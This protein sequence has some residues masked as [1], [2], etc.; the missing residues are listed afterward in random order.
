M[1]KLSKETNYDWYIKDHPQYQGKFIPGQTLTEKTTKDLIKI[2][3][4]I[5]YLPS[6]TSH[7]QIIQDGI[8]FAFTVNGDIAYEYAF[9][10]IPVM[11]GS[12]NCY[13]INYEF[14]IHSLDKD[15]FEKKIKNLRNLNHKIQKDEVL[16]FYFMMSIYKNNNYLIDI[17]E[18]FLKQTS[19]WES[20]FSI[21]VYK[22]LVDNWNDKKHKITMNTLDRFFRSR[23][24]FLDY[25]HTN[26]SIDNLISDNI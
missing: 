6:Q 20:L 10:N 2:N 13:T 4:K 16:E 14:N 7:H 12:R 26:K 3:P 24:Y 9:F 15:D 17:Y 18:K 23:D 21:E 5:K 25:R 19:N 1:I 8:D 11:T 22:Y